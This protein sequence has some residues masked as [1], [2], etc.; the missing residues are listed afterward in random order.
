MR[1]SFGS[2]NIWLHPFKKKEYW[3]WEQVSGWG[4][5]DFGG[6]WCLLV[7]ISWISDSGLGGGK[8]NPVLRIK[9]DLNGLVLEE[10]GGPQKM[11][12]L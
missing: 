1:S 6:V 10:T 4:Q 3:L 9:D 8:N 11:Y 2:W 7:E 12:N 5:N